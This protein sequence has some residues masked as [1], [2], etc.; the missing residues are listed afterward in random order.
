MNQ[1]F[2]LVQPKIKSYPRINFNDAST[3]DKIAI[4]IIISKYLFIYLTLVSSVIYFYAHKTEPPSKVRF[5]SFCSDI[6]T[7]YLCLKY[8]FRMIRDSLSSTASSGFLSFTIEYSFN[9]IGLLGFGIWQE[10]TFVVCMWKKTRHL[11]RNMLEQN[12]ISVQK[13]VKCPLTGTLKN[14]M[15]WPRN[16]LINIDNIVVDGNASF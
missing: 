9:T 14:I 7:L 16:F 5:S 11:L 3:T 1:Y 13:R 12:I 8:C 4:M 10:T 2:K 15:I 6:I